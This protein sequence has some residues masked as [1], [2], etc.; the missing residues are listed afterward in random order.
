MNYDPF[1]P[2]GIIAGWKS[3]GIKIDRICWP[4]FPGNSNYFLTDDARELVYQLS[5]DGKWWV[6]EYCKET[7]RIRAIHNPLL[8]E[9]IVFE[10][11]QKEEMA[12]VKEGMIVSQ[13]FGSSIGKADDESV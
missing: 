13:Y 4:E 10:Q 2:M 5:C 8:I 1:S 3:N 12:I 11:I 6:V 7:G 9:T